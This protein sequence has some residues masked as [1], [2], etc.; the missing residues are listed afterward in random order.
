H[1]SGGRVD[2]VDAA[3]RFSHGFLFKIREH[4]KLLQGLD[5][6]VA[7]S[8]LTADYINS[9]GGRSVSVEQAK[10]SVE[11]LYEQSL[12]PT[13]GSSDPGDSQLT[14]DAAMLIRFLSAARR[15]GAS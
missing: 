3:D 15:G 12:Q 1:D 2:N 13:S 10:G 6:D 4:L 14:E 5:K 7:I 11:P 8:L 9:W